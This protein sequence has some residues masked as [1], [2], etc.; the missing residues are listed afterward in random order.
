M[1]WIFLPRDTFIF[2]CFLISYMNVRISTTE[3]WPRPSQV[4]ALNVF[5]RDIPL[6]LI[7]LM[8]MILITSSGTMA[9][10]VNFGYRR[11]RGK[12]AALMFAT[13]LLRL[14]F[15]SMQAFEWTKLI[16]GEHV[17]PW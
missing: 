1:M 11:D 16:V 5:G 3:V 7:A 6:F 14:T 9:M 13:A 2:S 12:T 17:R 4:F 8:T 10:A 15:V